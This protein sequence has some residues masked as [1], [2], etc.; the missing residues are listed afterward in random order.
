M[1]DQPQKV[2]TQAER[3]EKLRAANYW[4]ERYVVRTG[5]SPMN[6]RVKWAQLDCGHD[7]Y[8]WRRPSVGAVIVC[9]KCAEAAK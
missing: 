7:V 1:S 9:N 8:R 4:P 5:V 6:P 3:R 2:D